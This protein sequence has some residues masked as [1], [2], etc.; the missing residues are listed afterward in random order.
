MPFIHPG[1]FWTG[2]AAVAVPV[3]IHL[4]SRRRFRTRYWAAMRFL[5]ESLRENRR[6]LRIEELI[7]LLLR[8]LIVLVLAAGLARFTGCGASGILGD[9]AAK[10]VVYIL[11][12]SPSMTQR[13]GDTSAFASA[14][15]DLSAALAE[16]GQQD[17]VAVITTSAA[18]GDE[19]VLPLSFVGDL[20]IESLSARL[21]SLPA[22]DLSARTATALETAGDMLSGVDGPK[23][24]V[25]MSDCRAGDYSAGEEHQR[26][27]ER[28]AAIRD[29]GA[30]T[31]VMDYARPP[32]DNLTIRSM[33]LLD[34]FAIADAPARVRVTVQNNSPASA[35]AV[36]VGVDMLTPSGAGE[37]IEA[38]L[39]VAVIDSI[40]P[41]GR[42]FCEL[43]VTFPQAGPAVL[44]AEIPADELGADNTA[45]LA[46]DVRDAVRMLVVDGDADTSGR[47]GAA[48]FI[49][50]ALDP[51]NDGGYGYRVDVI[52]PGR[53]AETD[54]NDYHM[55]ALA[56]VPSFSPATAE[57]ALSEETDGESTDLRYPQIAALES[58]VRDGGGLLIFTGPRVNTRFYNRRLYRGGQGLLPVPLAAP[59]GESDLT[60][61]F[62]RLDAASIRDQGPLRVFSGEGAGLLEVFRFFG[63]TRTAQGDG[64]ADAGDADVLARFTDRERSPAV[65]SRAF[66]RGRVML[67]TTTADTQWTDWPVEPLGSYVAV[68]A[69]TVNV[70]ARP[71]PEG[72]NGPA[73]RPVAMDISERM[74]DAKVSLT[75]P[76]YPEVEKVTLAVR[77]DER[78]RRHVRYDR[79]EAAGV[80]TLQL[81][82]PVGEP[83]RVLPVRNIDPAEGELAP[84]GESAISAAAGEDDLE[85]VNRTEPQ[86]TE[87]AGMD[88]RRDYWKWA[89][90]A[91]LALLTTE[92]LLARRFGHYTDS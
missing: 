84:A 38:S 90:A 29:T 35:T 62:V 49:A 65:V 14:K 30:K 17:R 87:T 18:A 74:R 59:V 8:C 63:F 37:L 76:R 42:G 92:T 12:D 15:E 13:A 25:L 67:F 32:R 71:Q 86:R 40:K 4:L 5:L 57:M 83:R 48:T 21:E 10:T 80:Y 16:L 9:D 39:P 22:S 77:T 70:L 33:E 61:G 19:P 55:L 75:T 73:G 81:T 91:V 69:E 54:L 31:M 23:W 2:L 53:F 6:R 66:G 27:R 44:R 60:N 11:D 88:D 51:N 82:P 26:L 34:S 20:D 89:I 56:N 72:I 7:L 1:I 46:V 43:A 50:R 41:H 58:F 24:L 79:A 36:E 64:I 28:F 47:G 85:Y 78:N 3:V 68:M 45:Y 52:A